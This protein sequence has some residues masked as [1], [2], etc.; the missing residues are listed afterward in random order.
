[1]T[2]LPKRALLAVGLP[3][4]ALA[5]FGGSVAFAQS[6]G[7]GSSSSTDTPAQQA[8]SPTPGGS[9]PT[10]PGTPGTPGTHDPAN[11]PNMGGSG[12]SGAPANGSITGTA[13][14]RMRGPASA[15]NYQ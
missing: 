11:C 3:L 8:P 7:D 5:L 2:A 14:H 12:S 6:Q 4:G 15:S 10:A 13:F 1:M 9:A